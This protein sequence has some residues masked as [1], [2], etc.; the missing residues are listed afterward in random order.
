MS[1]LGIDTSTVLSTG[2]Q[3]GERSQVAALSQDQEKAA[4][5]AIQDKLGDTVTISDEGRAKLA[6]MMEEYGG[7]D[8]STLTSDQKDEIR[9]T[10]QEALGLSDE[11][12][13]ALDKQEASK[14]QDA[15][16]SATGQEASQDQQ[17]AAASSQGSGQAQSM[18][19]AQGSG[20]SGSSGSS[21]S[22]DE[23]D[24]LEK[25]IKDMQEEIETLTAKS[26]NDPDAKDELAT[27]R[28]E[29]ASLQ[30]QLAQLQ[31]SSSSSSS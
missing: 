24:T 28:A 10:F 22:S 2:Y 11:Q 16:G 27:K 21:D 15:S 23:E 14:G 19:Q 7:K 29:L 12:M 31:S 30:A 1:S 3:I 25:E 18:G 6:A 5:Q 4:V 17:S 26:V 8:P 20:G 13:A 9:S